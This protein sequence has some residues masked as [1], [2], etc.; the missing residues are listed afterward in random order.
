MNL[1]AQQC[2]QK[3]CSGNGHCVE[4]AGVTTCQCSE[5]FSGESC[6]DTAIKGMQGPIIYGAA[7]LCGIIV[8]IAVIALIL[9]KTAA[10]RFLHLS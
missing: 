2:K 5:G 9:K 10:S 8:V 7:G 4:I 3:L 6:Q 1:E